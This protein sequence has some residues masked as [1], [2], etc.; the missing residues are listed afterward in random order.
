MILLIFYYLEL[1]QELFKVLFCVQAIELQSDWV[2]KQTGGFG[3][4]RE[5]LASE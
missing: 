3:R 4:N 5:A 2:K 1:F